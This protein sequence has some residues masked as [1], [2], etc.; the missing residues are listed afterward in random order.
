[1]P[2]KIDFSQVSFLI[3]DDNPLSIELLRD[4]LGM[5]GAT[6]VRSATTVERARRMLRRE[7]V[8]IVITEHH[9]RPDNGFALIDWIR[10]AAHSPDRM[11]PVIMLTANSEQYYVTQARDAGVTEFLAKPFNVEGLYRRLVSIVTRPRSFVNADSYF[12]PDRRRR[13][14]LYDGKDKRSVE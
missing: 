11:T 4:I 13:Q 7:P 10:N 5:L 8:D 12:G 2:E 9:L 6:A 3:V 14:V 1:M